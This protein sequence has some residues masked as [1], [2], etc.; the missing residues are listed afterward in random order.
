MSGICFPF[1]NMSFKVLLSG[2]MTFIDGKGENFHCTSG[3]NISY[4]KRVIGG[5][6][7]FFFA[8]TGWPVKYGR[9]FLVPCIK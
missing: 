9:D 6:G 2:K 1:S 4:C 5:G 3:K 7:N 8:T